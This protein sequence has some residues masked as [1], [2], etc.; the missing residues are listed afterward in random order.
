[1]S[2]GPP[3]HLRGLFNSLSPSICASKSSNDAPDETSACVRHERMYQMSHDEQQDVWLPALS[4][5]QPWAT[6][7]AC[8]AKRIE[9][10]SRATATR[11][12]L[13][14]HVAKAFPPEAYRLADT[15]P[16]R[17]AL[18]SAGDVPKSA[19]GS[20]NDSWLLPRGQ[21]IAIARLTNIVRLPSTELVITEQERAFGNYADGRDA[22][23]FSA[24]HALP[25][26]IPAR[27]ALGLWRWDIPVTMQSWVTA[28]ITA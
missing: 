8:G 12:W 10:R 27:G 28:R 14:I 3:P 5:T 23:I 15:P 13:A 20:A 4:L 19:S 17:A 24:V 22:W 25:A 7:V 1:M 2:L 6:L 18:S 16:F 26:P 21:V 11:G 9:T